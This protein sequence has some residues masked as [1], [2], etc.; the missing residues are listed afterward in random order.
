MP[1]DEAEQARPDL[2]HHIFRLAL[3]GRLFRAPISANPQ[4][5]LDFGTGTGI[6]AMDFGD[7]FPSA[8]VIG[9]D[10]SP[11][12]PDWVPPN[13]KFYVDDVES[14]W[15]DADGRD[16]GHDFIYGRAMAGS[17]RDWVGCII[18]YCAL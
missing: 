11:I 14:D 2:H 13:V 9:T 17:I 18:K 8:Q 1:N 10:L 6:W 16:T 15:V 12:Q 5:V 3:D 7:E 4:R